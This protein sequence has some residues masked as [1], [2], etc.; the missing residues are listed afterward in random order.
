LVQEI[1]FLLS[2]Y[3][4]MFVGLISGSE[5]ILKECKPVQPRSVYK[6]KSGIIINKNV[7]DAKVI[8]RRDS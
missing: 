2:I 7:M 1:Q 8:R 3:Y 6:I 5:S 4:F